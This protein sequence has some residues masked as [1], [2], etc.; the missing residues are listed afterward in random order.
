MKGLAITSKGIEETA[1]IEIKQLINADCEVYNGCVIFNFKEFRDLCL[2]CYK[3]QSIDRALH[4]IGN[5]QF[6][7][8]NEVPQTCPSQRRPLDT[9]AHAGRPFSGH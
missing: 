5:F 9:H 3:S 8:L 4:L 6:K 2:L 1:S 7:N